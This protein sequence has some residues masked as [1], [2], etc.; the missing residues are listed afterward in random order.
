MYREMH[1]FVFYMINVQSDRDEVQNVFLSGFTDIIYNDK[2][3]IYND[4]YIIFVT[5]VAIIF[6][7]IR[8]QHQRN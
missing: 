4:T 7:F 1:G 5:F 8:N 3:I 6:I 2:Y